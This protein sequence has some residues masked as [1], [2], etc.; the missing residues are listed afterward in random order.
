VKKIIP[1]VIIL[2]FFFTVLNSK[3]DNYEK[4]KEFH[5]KYFSGEIEKIIEGRGTKIYYDNDN[6]FYEDDYEGIKLL[7]GDLIRKNGSEITIIRK[8]NN[9]DYVEIGKGKSIEPKKSYFDYFFG[10]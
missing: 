1:I 4:S 2:I 5:L 9:G 3:T 10:I 6:F 7:V 8:N